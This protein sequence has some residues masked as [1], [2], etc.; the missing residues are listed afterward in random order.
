ML[1]TFILYTGLAILFAKIIKRSSGM[2]VG[3]LVLICIA[4]ALF[5]AFRGEAG[6]D[7]WSYRNIYEMPSAYFVRTDVEIGYKILM[8]LC[9]RIRLPY[10]A[11]FFIMSFFTSFFFLLAIREERNDIDIETA[12]LVYF[13]DFY[14]ICIFYYNHI[15]LLLYDY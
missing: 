2:H 14:L 3:I 11:L 13:F 1:I 5:S 15:N 4:M 10:V 12:Y 7:S 6:T 9:N 8:Y